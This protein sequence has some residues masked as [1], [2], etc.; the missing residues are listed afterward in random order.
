MLT[1]TSEA[2]QVIRTVTAD[3]ELPDG[4]GIR[5]A[6]GLDGSQ[7]LRLT[8]APSPEAGDQ[9]V[10]EQGARV[11]LEPTAAMLLD[12]KTLD[13]QVD[14]QGDIAFTIG[15]HPGEN[16]GENPGERT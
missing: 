6:S 13:A 15:E 10:E 16:A 5:I 3:P 7:E 1:L 12:D 14:P 8:V 2:V 4:T 11:Y 9:V